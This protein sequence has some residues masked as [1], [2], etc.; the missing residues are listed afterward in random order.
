MTHPNQFDVIVIGGGIAGI[1]AAAMI[2]DQASV[3]VLEAEPLCGYHATGRS[4]AIYIP[5]YGGAEVCQLTAASESYFITG[6]EN[7]NGQSFFKERGLLSL[8]GA[9]E[10]D[11]MT[12][13]L[14]ESSSP[15]E[16]SVDEAIDLVP[17]LKAD[18]IVRAAIERAARDIDTDL[19][20]QSWIKL[21]R[22]HGGEIKTGQAVSSIQKLAAGWVVETKNHKYHAPVV[23]NAA[24]PWADR[25][26]LLAGVKAVA[27]QPCRR[28]AAMIALPASYDLNHWP[29][30]G[31]VAV[32]WYARPM[33]GKLMLSPGDEDP[34]EPH[35]AFAD[36]MT[37]LEGIDR[38][39]S[40]VTVPVDRVEHTW[41]GLRTLAKDKIPV[42]G[43]D[44]A[45]EGFFWL[46][47]QGGCGFQTAPALSRLVSKLVLDQQL[48]AA[49]QTL[50]KALSPNRLQYPVML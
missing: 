33:G 40:A 14:A 32:T 6:N 42:V 29:L 21:C 47:G 41:A 7:S 31:S 28:S 43:W 26:A 44:S 30:F 13:Y 48:S 12:A 4:A 35:D 17:I 27:L 45:L 8:A 50:V 3:V 34:V 19:L 39:E 5:S 38:Y 10:E 22:S 25:V 1:G 23:I 16:I 11:I 36:D 49:E 20:L 15:V 18:A 9:G 2:S 24:G 46:A 37:I